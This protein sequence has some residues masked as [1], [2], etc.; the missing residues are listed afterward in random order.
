MVSRQE[1]QNIFLN[2]KEFQCTEHVFVALNLSVRVAFVVA[3]SVLLALHYRSAQH[4][5][6]I[7]DRWKAVTDQTAGPKKEQV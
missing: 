5:L 2:G 4:H 7:Q 1:A 3:H 6:Q